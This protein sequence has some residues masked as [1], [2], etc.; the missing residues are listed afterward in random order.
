MP[1]PLFSAIFKTNAFSNK[2]IKKPKIKKC[3]M[4]KGKIK[5]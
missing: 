3:F 1:K 2:K 5:I 4:K